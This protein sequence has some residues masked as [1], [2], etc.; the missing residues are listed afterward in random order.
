MR[1]RFYAHP[2][3]AFHRLRRPFGCDTLPNSLPGFRG[4]LEHGGIAHG[5][6][7]ARGQFG[8]IARREQ[9][10]RPVRADLFGNARKICAD[11]GYAAQNGFGDGTSESLRP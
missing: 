11:D 8:G 2:N 3:R 9:A 10:F 4:F 1:R 6:R 7:H 5:L